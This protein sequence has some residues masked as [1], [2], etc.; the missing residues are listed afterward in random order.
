MSNQKAEA[1]KALVTLAAASRE[2]GL[3]YHTLR[4][5]VLI[6]R[7]PHICVAGRT[8]RVRM[9]QVRALMAEHAAA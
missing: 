4:R 8:R 6:G 5:L 3:A 2:S 7:I 1:A 9:S